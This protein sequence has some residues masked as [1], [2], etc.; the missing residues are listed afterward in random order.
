M[1]TLLEKNDH[2]E[3]DDT[4]LLTE[5]SIQHYL[6]MIGQLQRLVTLR[7]FDIHAKVTTMSIFRSAPRKGYLEKLHRISCYVQMTKHYSTRYRTEEPNYS[8]LP[9][10]KHD[11]STQFMG[12]FKTL[13]PTSDPNLLA[14]LS[15]LLPHL[16]SIFYSALPLVHPSL[17][18]SISATKFQPIGIL[19]SKQQWRQLHMVLSLW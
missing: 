4:E 2:P 5:E 13:S 18:A 14:N 7:R 8:Y 19:R 3:L 10:L 15:L 9:N 17:H 11:W 12:M 1:R 16:M 6:T